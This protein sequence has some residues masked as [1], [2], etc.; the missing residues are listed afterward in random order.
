MYKVFIKNR[1]LFFI[2]S[3]EINM[4]I[5]LNFSISVACSIQNQLID[6]LNKVPDEFPICIF[7]DDPESAINLFFSGYDFIEAAG[8]IVKRKEKYLFIKRNGFWDIPKGKIEWNESIEDAAIREV[9]EECGIDGVELEEKLCITYHVYEY[10]KTPTI[11]KTYWYKMSY[12]GDKRVKAQK[13]EGITK[14]VWK[15]SDELQ[16]IRKNTFATILE[17]IDAY[18]FE[19]EN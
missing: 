4:Q 13:E 18:F 19:D 11:K 5:G 12:T 14:V 6:F 9:E 1:P 15:A 10:N 16:K 8:G 17:V 3:S 2:S 7:S